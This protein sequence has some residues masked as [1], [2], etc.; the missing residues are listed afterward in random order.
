MQLM[1]HEIEFS[2][3]LVEVVFKQ[4]QE[5]VFALGLSEACKL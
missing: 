5:Q 2:Q 1:G 3:G 4:K